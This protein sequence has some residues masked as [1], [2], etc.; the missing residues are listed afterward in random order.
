MHVSFAA[1]I[2][3][4]VRKE[5]QNPRDRLVAGVQRKSDSQLFLFI[6]VRL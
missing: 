2:R 5:K 3:Q 4:C 6:V 1:I